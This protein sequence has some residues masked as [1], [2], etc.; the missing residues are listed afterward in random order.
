MHN[1]LFLL[2]RHGETPLNKSHAHVGHSDIGLDDDGQKQAEEAAQFLSH[3]PNEIRHVISSPR[4][5]T[6]ETA[7]I[8]CA[9]LGI[10]EYLVDDR[11]T[12]LDVGD[13]TG[14]NEF[15]N[16]IDE[17]LK[18]TSKK[19][20]NGESVDDFELRQNDFAQDLVHWIESG[21]MEA[22]AIVVVT[23]S[24]VIAYWHNIQ[25]PNEKIE[26][27]QSLLRP[28]GIAEVTDDGVFPL[29]R[30]AKT[31]EEKQNDKMDPAV[32]LYMPP[33]ALGDGGAK[34]GT[35]VLGL[36]DGRCVSVHADDD[37][38]NT[39]VS[40]EHGVCGIYVHGVLDSLVQ[41]QPTISRTEAGYINKGAPTNCGKCEYFTYDQEFGCLKVDGRKTAKGK[42]ESGGCCNRWDPK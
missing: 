16:P 38:T 22:G 36:S 24:P 23:H 29:F 42:I 35:C 41:I 10:D 19:F 2:A 17:Y 37:K 32:V 13:F 1:S 15:E 40:L 12:D 9:T 8:I 26:L 34:C 14:Q 20:P 27:H 4:T 3:W 11:L 25:H 31:A 7:A 18:G 39:D 33:E 6:Q 5:R 28:G 30:K 21:Q